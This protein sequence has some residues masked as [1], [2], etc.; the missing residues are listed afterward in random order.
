MKLK[1]IRGIWGMAEHSLKANLEKIKEG[2]FDGVEMGAPA[3]P[4]VRKE[5]KCMLDDLDLDY[6]GQQWSAGNSIEEHI[7]SFRTQFDTNADMSPIHINSHTGKDWYGLDQNVEIYEAANQHAESSGIKLVHEIHRGRATF[8]TDSLLN[9][10]ERLPETRLCADFSHWCCVHESFLEDQTFQVEKAIQH[11]D[12]FHAR[13]GH[14]QASQINDPRVPEWKH[15]LDKHLAWWDRIVEV[16]K[17][18]GSKVLYCCPE[19]GPYP[20]MTELPFSR[21]PLT[22]LW[23]INQWMFELLKKRYHY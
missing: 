23:E 7:E 5:L 16:K 1:F 22:D 6:I 11:T 12:Y 21:S 20:Y 3:D 18:R 4:Q 13:V 14:T 10:L 17:E 8:C 19:F 15:A 9:L 2:G